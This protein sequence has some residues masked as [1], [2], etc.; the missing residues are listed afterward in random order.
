MLA[1]GRILEHGARAALAADPA[2]RFAAL[3]RSGLAD[4]LV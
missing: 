3:L 4:S 1:D 2:S